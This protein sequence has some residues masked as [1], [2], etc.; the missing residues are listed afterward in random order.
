MYLSVPEDKL[1]INEGI[2]N[3][4]NLIFTPNQNTTL[5]SIVRN[6]LLHRLSPFHHSSD[7][8]RYK[9]KRWWRCSSR[10]VDVL[11][12]N[13]LFTVHLSWWSEIGIECVGEAVCKRGSNLSSWVNRRRSN[14][15]MDCQSYSLKRTNICLRYI[16]QFLFLLLLPPP[17]PPSSF[18][19]QF[20][21]AA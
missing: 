5:I 2:Q 18:K 15:L 4:N 7:F 6:L 11:H 12:G 17:P 3:P 9:Q 16:P 21:W 19:G 13:D 8:E 14:R 20:L 10:V 1:L